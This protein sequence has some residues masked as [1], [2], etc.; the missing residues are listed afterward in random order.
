ML[1]NWFIILKLLHLLVNELLLLPLILLPDVGNILVSP[2]VLIVHI[3]LPR[4]KFNGYLVVVVGPHLLLE[5]IV[6]DTLSIRPYLILLHLLV[7]ICPFLLHFYFV[8]GDYLLF[9]IVCEEFL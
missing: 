5:I 4:R 1:I 3:I 8:I 9:V 7:P 6:G 2:L